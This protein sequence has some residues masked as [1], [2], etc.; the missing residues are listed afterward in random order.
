[1]KLF[2]VLDPGMLTTVQDRGRYGY[3]RYGVPVSGAMDSFA[4][5]AANRLVA[6][7][8]TAAALEMTLLGPRL[9][10]LAATTIALAGADLGAVIDGQPLPLWESVS[11]HEGAALWFQGPRDGIRGYLA[12][13]GGIDVPIILGSRS[14]YL[15]S[16]LGGLEGRALVSGDVLEGVQTAAPGGHRTFPADQRP[17]YGHDHPLRVVL[18]PQDDRFTSEGLLTFFCSTYQVTPQSDRMGCRLTGPP[19]EHR[20]G[21]DIVSDGS[22]LGAVQVAGDG[23]PIVLMADRGTAGG[24]TKIATVISADV[25]RLAQATPG[26]R[27]HFQPVT[28]EEAHEILRERER[29]LETLHIV[30]THARSAAVAAA[31]VARLLAQ[32]KTDGR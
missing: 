9:R 32:Q 11:V 4:L 28:V 20:A 22:P 23:M 7:P 3:Q 8:D 25:A 24:Y 1:M 5:R 6:N 12:V 30:P 27:V 21:P 13:A 10:V 29:M 15:R 26:D 19:I 31:T 14:T 18:G 2:E 17:A 16:R